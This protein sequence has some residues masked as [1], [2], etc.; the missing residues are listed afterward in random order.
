MPLQIHH[1]SS[2]LCHYANLFWAWDDYAPPHPKERIL[3]FGM[4]ELNIN[5]SDDPYVMMYPHDQ[6]H[7]HRI[8]QAIVNGAR[9]EFFVVDTSRPASLLS[10]WFKAGGARAF[11]GVSASELH[12]LHI[13]LRDLWG[14]CADE[15][16]ERLHQVKTTQA[17][18]DLL[19]AFLC[20]R[21]THYHPRHRVIDFSL[22]YLNHGEDIGAIVN[23]I[24][25]SST[26]FIQLFKEEIG[27]TPK[28]YSQIQRFQ[29]A[30]QMIAN[31]LQPNWADIALA[32]G[33]YDQSHFIN[34]FQRFAGISPSEYIPQDK[35]HSSNLAMS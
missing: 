17:R 16:Y 13:P 29:R 1:P 31:T 32:C 27:M 21:L 19:E 33:Y 8:H 6:F 7:P 14:N 10:V 3:P 15:L 30:V 22:G 4:M 35:D 2:P 5:L 23:Q 11:F 24:S 34:A 20:R 18:F 25:L 9:S 12:N 26:R 28:L